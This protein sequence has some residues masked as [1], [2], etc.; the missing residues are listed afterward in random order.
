MA[1]KSK[2]AYIIVHC[3]DSL[4]GDKAEINKWHVERG[5]PEIGYNWVIYNQYPT[6]LSLKA[7]KPVLAN[8][9]LLVGGR[10]MDKDGDFD[11]EVGAHCVGYNDNG[12]GICLVGDLDKR[13]ALS[14]TDAQ[15]ETLYA[16]L[17]DRCTKYSIPVEHILGHCE[18]AQGKRD[19]KTCPELETELVRQEVRRRMAPRSD[20][21][22]A[23][24][25]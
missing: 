18:T 24:G 1:R 9:G 7:S 23:N 13:G 17:I 15:M 12:L 8:D 5:W 3:S 25:P 11:E 4:W 6:Y 2:I 10:D 16:F 19:G 21:G 14:F 20:G 22:C